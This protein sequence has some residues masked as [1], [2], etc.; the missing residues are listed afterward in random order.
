M[1]VGCIRGHRET[2]SSLPGTNLG[3]RRHAARDD[4]GR[5]SIGLG[6]ARGTNSGAMADGD[7]W[8]PSYVLTATVRQQRSPEKRK[9]QQALT[10]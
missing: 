6:A 5:R 9:G 10:C 2:P 8:Q 4:L 1:E 3:A 7:A